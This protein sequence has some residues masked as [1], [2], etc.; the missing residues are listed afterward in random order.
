MASNMMEL[1][2]SRFQFNLFFP[3]IECLRMKT[4]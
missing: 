4:T 2:K 3:R 1:M